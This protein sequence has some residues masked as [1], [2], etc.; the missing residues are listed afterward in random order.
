[1]NQLKNK[2]SV[3]RRTKESYIEVALDF[4]GLHED[5]KTDIRTPIPFFNHMLEHIAYRSGINMSVLFKMDKF[6]LN[7]I[8]F[9]DI[10]MA[11]GKAVSTYLQENISQGIPGFSDGVG[12]IDEAHASCAMSF[13][14][15][16]YFCLNEQVEVPP[17]TE[18]TLSEDLETFFEGFVQGAM[19]TLHLDINRGR[20]GHHIWEAAYRAFGVAL[21]RAL[22]PDESRRGLT[23]GVCGTIA[24]EINMKE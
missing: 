9:E 20:N 15:R 7:H 17:Q 14:N 12:I 6:D 22:T 10:G 3:K 8:V 4:G 2:I 13:E 23:S 18:G 11:I 21:R 19:C 1:M 16:A 24:Y 5:Y